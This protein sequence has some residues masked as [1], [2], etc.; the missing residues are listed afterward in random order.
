[1]AAKCLN[2]GYVMSTNQEIQSAVYAGIKGVG[3]YALD[4]LKAVASAAKEVAKVVGPMTV[5]AVAGP[6]NSHSIKCPK[7]GESERWSDV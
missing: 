7:C 4:F 5:G 2:C 3:S 1:M 6:L